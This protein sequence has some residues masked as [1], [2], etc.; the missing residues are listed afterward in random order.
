MRAVLVVAV[1]LLASLAGCM[2]RDEPDAGAEEPALVEPAQ[3]AAK[4]NAPTPTTAKPTNA[5]TPAAGETTTAGT[6]GAPHA[7]D[8]WAGKERVLLMDADVAMSPTDRS[9]IQAAGADR[10][11]ALGAKDVT[12]P[13]GSI[14]FEGTGRLLATLTWVDPTITGM[15]L[16]YHGAGDPTLSEP[17]PAASGETVEVEVSATM[18]DPPHSSA[19]RWLFRLLPTSQGPIG[20]AEG[21]VHVRI[22]IEKMRDIEIFPAHPDQ[23]NGSATI[24]LLDAEGEVERNGAL[25]TVFDSGIEGKRADLGFQ[26]SAPVP[27]EAAVIYVRFTLKEAFS[28]DP[29]QDTGSIALRYHGA[30]STTL[31]DA[32]LVSSQG[33]EFVYRIS[34]STTEGDGY[35]ATESQWRFVPGLAS[36]GA[37]PD[38]VVAPCAEERVG[39][40]ILAI[41]A[42]ADTGPGILG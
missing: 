16:R 15:A 3:A 5:S 39:G 17:F 12:L 30:D 36:A 38:C 40:S 4:P 8:Y 34:P 1:L 6:G 10:E 9:A 13:D 18:T 37:S 35:Y 21:A 42:R 26:P 11:P 23:F 32:E 20:V 24:K 31:Q 41:A 29:T 27:L 19:S 25:T 7:H 22:E 2:G 14:V 28:T 33:K